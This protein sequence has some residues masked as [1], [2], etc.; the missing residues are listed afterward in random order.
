MERNLIQFSMCGR[1]GKYYPY[2]AVKP[3]NRQ[4]TLLLINSKPLKVNQIAGRLEF[5]K[6]EIIESLM[7]LKK[8][9]LVK[10]AEGRYSPSFAIF[11]R[12]D[13]N[14]LKALLEE[15]SIDVKEIVEKRVGEL[16]KLIS[17]LEC[18]KKGSRFPDLD[19]IVIGALTLDYK[20]LQVLHREKLLLY[21][22]KMP[23]NSNYIFS[24]FESGLINLKES[25]MWGHNSSFGKYWFSTHGKLP[26]DGSR[27]A[28]PDLAWRWDKH[29]D[30]KEIDRVMKRIGKLLELLSEHNL[31]LSD[32][33]KIV[34]NNKEKLLTE[35][36]LLLTLE[37]IV[38]EEKKWK[39]NRPFLTTS[40]LKK[41]RSF[42]ES[43]LKYI[44]KF[45]RAKQSR[46]IELYVQ[47][48]PSKNGIPFKE[49]FNPLYHLIFER[50]LDLLIASKVINSPPLRKDKGRYSP[51]VGVGIQNFFPI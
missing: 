16:R 45:L 1:A 5:D 6:E 35:L 4:R 42:S 34:R 43:T 25:W 24:G 28:F 50:A 46:M 13:Q 47:T 49:A 33:N 38:E 20:G 12:K 2:E 37:Y 7:A 18:T 27:E 3:E 30:S 15:L 44:S 10:D 41:I 21:G 9:G 40:D 11:T 48:S 22:K 39:T 51:F 32:L 26:P 8:C 29:T 31:S 14:I 17:D 36:T 19:Y 23:G